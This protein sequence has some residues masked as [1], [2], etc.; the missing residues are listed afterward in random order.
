MKKIKKIAKNLFGAKRM[1]TLALIQLCGNI[2]TYDQNAASDYT[3]GT[4]AL[5]TV[6]EANA[7]WI[8]HTQT[9]YDKM[10]IRLNKTRY[11]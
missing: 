4:D 8:N 2:A 11:K 6:T 9:K 5:A 7:F 10:N 1:K 3:A